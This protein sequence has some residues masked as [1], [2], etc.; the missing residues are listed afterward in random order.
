MTPGWEHKADFYSGLWMKKEEP[1]L[2]V[3]YTFPTPQ[4]VLK[5]TS[6]YSAPSFNLKPEGA[7]VSRRASCCQSQP[8]TSPYIQFLLGW[9][10]NL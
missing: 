4:L 7:E 1:R 2:T 6:P 3:R 10:F 5:N 9:R 8:A